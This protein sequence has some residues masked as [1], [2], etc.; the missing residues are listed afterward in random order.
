MKRKCIPLRT[1]SRITTA[2]TLTAAFLSLSS[3]A[4]TIPNPSFEADTFN[5]APGFITG[6]AP[7]T[8]WSANSDTSVGLNPA[9]GSSPFADNGII[10]DGNNVAFLQQGG[11]LTTTISG[12]NAGQTY[13][14]TFRANAQT[15][16]AAGQYP[17]INVAVAFVTLWDLTVYTMGTNMPYAYLAFEFTASG[18]TETLTLF[19]D[20]S[21]TSTTTVLI[22]DFRI[23][24]QGKWSVAAW[25][26]D[27]DSGL[28]A[29]YLYT[30]S[31]NFGSS[32]CPIIN[33]IGFTGVPGINPAVPG[34]FSTASFGYT[35]SGDVNNLTS[36]TGT[37]S[38]LLARDFAYGGTIAP[39][40]AQTISLVGLT[41]G[42]EY[43]FTIYSVAWEEPD[44]A[45]RWV[46]VSAGDDRLTLNQDQFYNNNGILVSY[47]YTADASG[48]FTAKISPVNPNNVSMH[49]YGFSN[50]ETATRN[51]APV[52][53]LQPLPP[54]TIVAQGEP[55]TYTVAANGIPSLLSY[56]W[57]V[58][59]VAIPGA[60]GTSYSPANS[61]IYDVVVQNSEGS[62]T[63][64]VAKLTVGLPLINS[65]FE[66]DVFTVWPG[67]VRQNSAITGWN[68]LGGHGLN[69]VSDGRS[70]FADNGSIPLGNHVA[71]MQDDG[72]LSQV[73]HGFTVGNQYT[74]HY[75]ENSRTVVVNPALEVRVGPPGF[76]TNTI[77]PAHLVRSVGGG[78]PYYEKYSQTFIAT[79]PDLEVSFVKSNPLGGD[80]T[81]L[82][83]NVAVLPV[84]PGTVPVVVLNPEPRTVQV[85]DSASFLAVGMGSLP[86]TYQWLKDG[87]PVSGATGTTLSLTSI[88]KLD[89]ADYSL[90]FSNG[91]GSVTSLVAHLTVYEPIP[92]L[93]STGLDANRAPLADGLADPHFTLIENADTNS[94]F[95]IVEDSTV[96]PIS[97]GTWLRDTATSKWIGPQFNTSASAV[98][99]YIYRTTINLTDRDPKTVVILGQW[100][101]DNAGTDILVNGVSTANPQNASFSAY[102]AFSIYGTNV[103]F[104][105]GPNTIDFVVENLANIGYTGLRMEVLMSNV[106]IP[107]G[108]RPE[109]TA[110]PVGQTAVEG[111]TVTFTAGARGAA[112]LTY[113]WKKNGTPITDQ[114]TLTLTLTNVSAAANG[115]YTI[116]VSN[117]VGTATSLPA[118]L[119]VAYRPIP[120]VFGTGVGADGSLL[121][122]A[123]VDPHW[124]LS[125]SVDPLYPGPNAIVVND[126]WPIMAG[127]WCLNGPNSKW[128]APWADQS[129]TGGNPGGEYIYQTSVDLSGY[130]ITSVHLAGAWATDNS[131]TDVKLNGLSTGLTCPGFNVLT[132]FGITNG[133][134]AGV[135]TLDFTVANATNTDLTPN[136]TALR[137]D[138]RALLSI[139]PPAPK[140][141]ISRY[142]NTVAISWSPVAVGQKLQ[143]ATSLSGQWNDVANQTN[144]YTNSV[145]GTQFF[146]VFT[147]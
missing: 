61:G 127:V 107:P 85:G 4:Q 41:P 92:D 95:A 131:G 119:L 102:T 146:R 62:V 118:R 13:K 72:V 53:T 97:T 44:I 130:D 96:F 42:T 28:D 139:L 147:P 75:Y 46:T 31:Y 7:I 32:A 8:G 45:N 120:G 76:S 66:A 116:T 82:I 91:S 124:I 17:N 81:A 50:R 117:Q 30:H 137:V 23:T 60:N 54:V 79:G 63:S 11:S 125:Y 77:M 5:T 43:L 3:A 33:G 55:V 101:T 83:D 98:G 129:T 35:Y 114:T 12:L 26:S 74:V 93:F 19:N 144:P 34:K 58:N 21:S 14:V 135:N 69:P 88:Q 27:A 132:P 25:T 1:L 134:L 121:P 141:Q 51:F 65:S 142:G 122:A 84:E 38:A 99:R 2:I 40:N 16:P 140:L 110:Q 52:L 24:P 87:A 10:P 73:V 59:G 9:G 80:S 22:D 133:L 37:S 57:R 112:P 47:R 104:V 108:V 105:A 106:R 78:N 86:L 138:L 48:T 123:A 6:N 89:E 145:S 100:A 128:I 15:P 56:T 29:N 94:T 109:I 18:P 126:G 68:A 103:N 49:V 90:A 20:A 143:Y 36:L 67:Y 136:P 113:Q 71:F 70:P 39:T 111:D 115:D 64:V